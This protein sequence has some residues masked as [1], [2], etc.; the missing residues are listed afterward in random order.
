MA[1]VTFYKDDK[2]LKEMEIKSG[3][4]I[5]RAAKQG[6]VPL[7]HRCGGKAQCTTCMITIKDQ[8]GVTEMSQL[9]ADLVGYNAI[10]QGS[11]LGCQTRVL[12]EAEV[13]MPGDPYKERIKQLI[14]QQ[15]NGL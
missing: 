3:H 7:K 1:K 8:A 13:I 11:R 15:K 14:A 2:V 9:E 6:H 5:L 4:S 12:T 10:K